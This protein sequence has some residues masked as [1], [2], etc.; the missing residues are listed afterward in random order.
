MGRERGESANL[1]MAGQTDS[2]TYTRREILIRRIL[3]Y[4]GIALWVLV[5]MIPFMLLMLSI[6]REI[7]I[8]L[9][10]S[11]PESEL[12]VWMVMERDARGIGYSI[13]QVQANDDD[14]SLTV[15]QNIRYL[16]WEGE[17]E[18][19]AYCQT[20]ERESTNALWASV[21]AVEGACE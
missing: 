17:N 6:L 15:Q 14:L 4:G 18:R 13:P 8:D 12:R 20:Y 16:L 21:S 7:T 11:Y 2:R 5:L 10:G 1:A 3:F 19:I 9:P